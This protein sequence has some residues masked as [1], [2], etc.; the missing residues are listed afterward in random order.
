MVKFFHTAF[1]CLLL[2]VLAS[3]NQ[4]LCATGSS[5]A[6][7]ADPITIVC[8]KDNEPLSFVSKAGEPVGLMIDLWRLW[9][10]SRQ[11]REIHHGRLAG[12]A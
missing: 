11:A 9:G 2:L 1:C 4:A 3:A 5:T 8:M 7:S 6:A 10:K 12:F